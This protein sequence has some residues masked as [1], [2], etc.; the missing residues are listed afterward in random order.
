MKKYLLLASDPAC[1]DG[2]CPSIWLDQATGDVIVRGPDD[3][4]P[5]RERDVRFPAETWRALLAAL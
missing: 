1:V 4:D 5:T 2:D 3:T